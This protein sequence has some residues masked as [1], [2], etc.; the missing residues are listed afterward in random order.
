MS[1]AF[2]FVLLASAHY[3]QA[4]SARARPSVSSIFSFGNSY[5]DTGNFVKLA[6][7]L[8]PVIPFN[9]LPYGETYFRRPNGRASNGRL[10]ID[11]IGAF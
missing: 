4:Y 8:I 1:I 11:F 7:P 10:T 5:A 3:A 6:A 2:L 9:N